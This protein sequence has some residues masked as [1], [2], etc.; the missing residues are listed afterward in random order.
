MSRY[1]APSALLATG[2]NDRVLFEVAAD[3]LITAIT[4]RATAADIG[5][6]EV[7][8]GAVVPGMPCLHSNA[9]QRGMAGLTEKG[10]PQGDSFW[11]WRKLMYHFL[12]GLRPDD[13]EAIATQVYIEMLRGGY[14]SVAEF[15]YLHHDAG[16]R[17]YANRA[18]VGERLLAAA[19]ATGIAQTLLP[20]LYAHDNFGGT[21]PTVGQRRFINDAAGYQQIVE[22]LLK[23]VQGHPAQ[24]IGIAP[25]SLRAVTPAQLTAAVSLADSLQP[26]MPIHLNLAAQLKEV[27]DCLAWSGQRPVAWLLD[28]V[29]VDGRWCVLHATHTEIVEAERLARSGVVAGL[30]PTTEGDLGDGFF[31]AVP[32][33]RAGGRIGIGSDSHVGVDPFLE[34]KLFEY[35]QRLRFERRNVLA[36]GIGDSLGGHLYRIT[37]AGGAQAIGQPVGSLAVGN[38]AD[39]LVLDDDDPALAEQRHDGLLDAAIFGPARQPV[40]DVMVAGRWVL[41]DGQH[42]QAAASFARYRAVMKRLLA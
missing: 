39:W 4:P 5:A 6:A 42:P 3:G 13:V 38:R 12:E 9:F 36:K 1:L 2:W 16:G 7:L 30:C 40:R 34:L 8:D 28:H 41:R 31:N 23:A 27:N 35:G 18:E 29:A 11:S 20:V 32:Y 17:P 15:H 33:L 37:A 14:T 24:R 10:G 22:A 25:H 26:G 21:P 19:D